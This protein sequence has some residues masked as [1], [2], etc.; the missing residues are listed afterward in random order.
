[1]THHQDCDGYRLSHR[2]NVEREHT[3]SK[4]TPFLYRAVCEECGASRLGSCET[5]SRARDM[6][7][8][9]TMEVECDGRCLAWGL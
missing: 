5:E 1:M 7:A 3:G 6:L 2:L 8:G 9:H 4:R